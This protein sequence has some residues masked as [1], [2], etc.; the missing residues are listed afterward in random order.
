MAADERQKVK[1]EQKKAQAEA[2]RQ[3]AEKTA[4]ALRQKIQKTRSAVFAAARIGDAAK[5]KKGI[6][7]DD[8]DAAGGEVKTGCDE[9]V[10]PKPKD[11]Q[12]A[13]L[14]IATKNGDLE[15]VQW[16]DA[17][18]D[19]NPLISY[20]PPLTYVLQTQMRRKEMPKD[21]L[22][23]ISLSSWAT[24]RSSPISSTSIH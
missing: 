20:T 16:L 19:F 21:I 23:S 11:S 1:T 24:Y 22:L 2:Q 7:E 17:H 6:W 9:F 10:N 3:K 18:S 15:L 4:R 13:L 14:H 5:V 12:E 8:V